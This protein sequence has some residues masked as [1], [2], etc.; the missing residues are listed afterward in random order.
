[1]TPPPD[2]TLPVIHAIRILHKDIYG[3][4]GTFSKRDK[5][6]I[7]ATIETLCI[8]VLSLAVESAFKPRYQKKIPLEILRIKIE[9]LKHLVRTEHELGIIDS[10]T[11]LRLGG[12][13]VEISKMTNG[14]ISY[15]AQKE[16]PS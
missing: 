3:T 7:H 11:Y 2:A 12:Q 6:G 1:M 5:L 15:I 4:S 16:L 9:V 10:K 14:W 8:E 13:I